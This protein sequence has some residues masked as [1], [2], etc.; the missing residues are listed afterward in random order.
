[1]H[2][3]I[4][5]GI[6]LVILILGALCTRRIIEPA[7]LSSIIAV[8]MLYGTDFVNGYLEKMYQVLADPSF[9]L[10][11][12]VGIGFTGISALADASGAMAGFRRI[13]EKKCK[14]Q[15]T[16]IFCTW[17]LGAIVF[18]DDYLNALA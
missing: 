18:I 15:H 2:S 11:I 9:Q 4:I 10:L 13:M 17:L 1:M 3:E 6:P 14:T 16:T 8:I 5:G 12:I 7:C